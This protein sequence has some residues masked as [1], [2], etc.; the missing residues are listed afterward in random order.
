MQLEGEGLC[1]LPKRDG[2]RERACMLE[3]CASLYMYIYI[4][5]IQVLCHYITDALQVSNQTD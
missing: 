3:N 2:A 5:S 1:A 4:Q